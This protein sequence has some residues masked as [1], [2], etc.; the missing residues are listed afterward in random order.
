ML[1]PGDRKKKKILLM[2]IGVA[3]IVFLLLV[4][5]LL[6]LKNVWNFN[7]LSLRSADGEQSWAQ[8][9]ADFSQTI[10]DTR[11]KLEEMR[12]GENLKTEIAT[13]ALMQALV[14]EI[15]Q[16]A[17][18]STTTASFAPSALPATGSSP[19]VTPPLATSTPAKAGCPV[20]IDCMPKII[21]PGETP[22]G[23]CQ[24]PAGCEGITQIVY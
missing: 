10:T 9:K 5:W 2:K 7:R 19:L 3:V 16:S 6:N 14:E 23:P 18:S 24:V 4:I 21:S 11:T 15:N 17:S 20:Y 8:I 22:P 12:V 1:E 13:S